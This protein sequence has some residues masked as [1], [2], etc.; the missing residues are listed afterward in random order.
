MYFFRMPNWATRCAVL[1]SECHKSYGQ[2]KEAAHQLILLTSEDAD[3]RSAVLLEQ[4]ALSFLR[5]GLRPNSS[6]GIINLNKSY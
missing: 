3:L 6:A 4:A 2:Y 5:A 1:A